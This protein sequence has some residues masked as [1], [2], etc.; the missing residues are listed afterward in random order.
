MDQ[1]LIENIGELQLYRHLYKLL[2]IIKEGFMDLREARFICKF[3]QYDLMIKSGVSQPR[4]SLIERGYVI[5]TE[6]ERKKIAKALNY[7]VTD[8]FP[9]NGGRQEEERAHEQII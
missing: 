3:S 9:E 5:P 4:I 2:L 1:V 7:K 8:I 6:D